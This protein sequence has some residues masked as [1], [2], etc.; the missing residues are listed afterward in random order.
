VNGNFIRVLR[1]LAVAAA[2]AAVAACAPVRT[3]G[4]IAQVTAQQSRE[5]KLATRTSW[6]LE[7]HFTVSDGRDG[8]SG[9]LTWQADGSNYSLILRAPVT[10]K[11]VELEGGP[12]GAV[13][14]GLRVTPIHGDD[15][16]ALLADEFGWHMPVQQLT[17]WVRGLR[18]PDGSAQVSYGENGLPSL[19]LQDGWS[20]EYRDWYADTDPPLPRKIFAAKPPY[21][22]RLLIE[23]W[24]IR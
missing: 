2:L 15:A 10:G 7:G 21:S 13:L 22:V 11:T 1:L 3:R 19:L 24:R 16:Q 17:W 9:T 12:G 6:N 5:A 8:G 14:T 20:V 18:A 23:K 4:T